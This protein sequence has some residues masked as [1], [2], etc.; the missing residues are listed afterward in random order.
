ME[1]YKKIY[2]HIP[3]SSTERFHEGWNVG[4]DGNGFLKE[5][6]SRTDILTDRLFATT[7]QMVTPMVYDRSRLWCDVERLN[8]DPL[9]GVGMGFCPDRLGRFTRTVGPALAAEIRESYDSWR[10]V[11]ME[12][13]ADGSLVIDCHSFTPET[14]CAVD[15]CI[16]VNDDQSR[17]DD[18]TLDWIR[19]QFEKVGIRVSLNDPYTNSIVF[20]DRHKSVMLEINK[21]LYL[22]DN[23]MEPRPDWYRVGNV[24]QKV[25][26]GLL[27]Q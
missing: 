1:T 21:K 25:Y 20:H 2:T 5:A 10:R 15:V 14:G 7:N 13:V 24:I 26:K 17:P 18:E 12:T 9:D 3:H 22:K 6:V 23:L 4:D 11:C 16:G 8:P 27:G 19:S